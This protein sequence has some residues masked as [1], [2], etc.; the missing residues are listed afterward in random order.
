M[1]KLYQYKKQGDGRDSWIV[2]EFDENDNL[3][4]KYMIYEDPL[5][6]KPTAVEA[7]L[8]ANSEEI[9]KIKLILNIK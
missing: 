3:V 4:N 5:Q 2:S 6:P 1:R 9:E 7:I 8:N